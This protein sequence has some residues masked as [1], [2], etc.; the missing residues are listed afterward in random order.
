MKKE[1]L[2][3]S[4]VA[5][6][7]NIQNAQGENRLF[8]TDILEKG[9]ADIAFGVGWQH[10]FRSI[11]DNGVSGTQKLDFTSEHIQFRYGLGESW[12]VGLALNDNSTYEVHTNFDNGQNF[13]STRYQGQQNPALWAKYGF[14]K[15]KNSPFSLSG[16][17]LVSPNTT[18]ND[19]GGTETVALYGGLDYGNGLK[20]YAEYR[21]DF[22]RD[23]KFSRVHSIS[24]GAYKTETE[25]F[26]LVA[27]VHYSR[28]EATDLDTALQQYGVGLAALLQ[29]GHNSYVYPRVAVYQNTSRDT[30]DGTVHWGGS[31]GKVLSVSLYH[32]F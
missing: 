6:L 1:Y 7:F 17:F 16:E 14:V 18:D 2:Y 22:P 21:G 28:F 27:D 32:L 13:L 3:V 29:V 4:L 11:T 12:H 30:T 31:Q 5:L 26:T 20:G 19:T 10:T 15:D 24:V 23:H 9:E 25:N 8:P